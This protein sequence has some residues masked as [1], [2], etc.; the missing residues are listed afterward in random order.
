MN[1]QVL[2]GRPF[3]EK[4]KNDIRENYKD[5]IEKIVQEYKWESDEIDRVREL[6]D[7]IKKMTLN[8]DNKL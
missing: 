4:R 1:K 8:K 7:K 5:I 2:Q 3:L 6:Q